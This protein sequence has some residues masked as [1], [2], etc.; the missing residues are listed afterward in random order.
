M[1]MQGLLFKKYEKKYPS[2]HKNIK[3]FLF[4]H[5]FF[6]LTCQGQ[7]ILVFAIQCLAPSGMGILR[8]SKY[9][10]SRVPGTQSSDFVYTEPTTC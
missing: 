5:R 7:G 3:L 1:K 4:F 10:T 6:F 9:R 8:K 2:R